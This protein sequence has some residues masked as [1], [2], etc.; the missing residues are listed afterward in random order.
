M[1]GGAPRTGLPL[2]RP[3]GR[4]SHKAPRPTRRLL[5]TPEK[6]GTGTSKTRSQSPFFPGCDHANASR[7][8]LNVDDPQARHSQGPS[9]D[10]LDDRGPD[11]GL[12]QFIRRAGRAADRRI[13]LRRLR[14]PGRG[15]LRDRQ[16]PPGL[17]RREDPT[18]QGPGSE[19]QGRE[20]PERLRQESPHPLPRTDRRS[21]H[22][23]RLL[24]L[25][26]HLATQGEQSRRD[27][28]AHEGEADSSRSIRRT[29]SSSRT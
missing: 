29:A 11:D 17:G 14:R 19:R 4:R 28:E 23:G 5:R 10:P 7:R 21:P 13:A 8:S 20:G 2:I 26:L 3:P 24:R 22:Q 6:R 25:R 12:Y 27:P 1:I 9:P 18:G 16:G 15:E